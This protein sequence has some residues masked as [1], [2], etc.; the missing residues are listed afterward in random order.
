MSFMDW[1]KWLLYF[2]A[3]VTLDNTARRGD[4]YRSTQLILINW[5]TFLSWMINTN[6]NHVHGPT[7]STDLTAPGISKAEITP[8]IERYQ[9][10]YGKVFLK[11]VIGDV[12]N[13]WHFTS[14]RSNR[15][16]HFYLYE[17]MKCNVDQLDVNMPNAA[18]VNSVITEMFLLNPR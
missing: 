6:A 10:R 7:C 16:Y 17:N 13:Y 5:N 9:L 18:V 4:K 12:Q 3:A 11:S 14:R 8:K 2:E 15:Y 1:Q